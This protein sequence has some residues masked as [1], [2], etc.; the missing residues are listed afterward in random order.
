MA[1]PASNAKEPRGKLSLGFALCDVEVLYH[2]FL[3]FSAIAVIITQS[4]I[5]NFYIIAFF[6]GNEHYVGTYFWFM[7]DLFIVCFFATSFVSA[8]RYIHLRYKLELD[9]KHNKE[10]IRKVIQDRIY[11]NVACLSPRYFGTLPFSFMAWLSYSVYLSAKIAVIFSS[12]IPTFMIA[13]KQDGSNCTS[14]DMGSDMNPH[15]MPPDDPIHKLGTNLLKV[16]VGLSAL[17]FI[18][19]LQ[20]HHNHQD[21]T[22]HGGYVLGVCHNIAVEV[23]DSA[24]FL[25]LL[26]VPQTSIDQLSIWNFNHVIIVLS[27]INLVL[28]TLTLYSMS[29]SDFGRRMHKVSKLTVVSQ[30]LNL[31]VVNVP[32]LAMRLYLWGKYNYEL[33]LFVV[34]NAC[35]IFLLVHNLTPGMLRWFEKWKFRRDKINDLNIKQDVIEDHS[36]MQDQA[37]TRRHSY[38]KARQLPIGEEGNIEPRQSGLDVPDAPS[39]SGLSIPMQDL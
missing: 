19:M 15:D 27:C 32:F 28:P 23:F 36:N 6:R 13:S 35:Y 33:S 30:S 34:K 4:T 2:G 16:S 25:S 20:A 3:C 1:G 17:V 8:Y 22:A 9:K 31:L 26:I 21:N 11:K 5:L 18:I 7:G 24:T 14:V 37:E 12:N 29:I 39:T 38:R 10:Q